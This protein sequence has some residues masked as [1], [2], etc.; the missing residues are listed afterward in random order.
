M[1]R[2]FF[3]LL[4]NLKKSY[5]GDSC[6][7]LNA[8]HVQVLKDLISFVETCNWSKS[9]ITKLY[10]KYWER[11]YEEL[12]VIFV[13]EGFKERACTTMRSQV[14]EIS[15][16]LYEMFGSYEIV[17]SAFSA[18]S[19]KSSRMTIK[20]GEMFITKLGMKIRIIN[21]DSGSKS[22]MSGL[23]VNLF[24]FGVECV[25]ENKYSLSECMNELVLLKTVSMGSIQKIC[26]E[27]DKDKLA[28]ILQALEKPFLIS[29]RKDV[30]KSRSYKDRPVGESDNYKVNKLY[31]NDLK[32][33]ILVALG[34]VK[35]K[36]LSAENASF[37][38]D[39]MVEES[40]GVDDCVLP[41]RFD[42][43]F[44]LCK[45]VQDL[46]TG[47]TKITD[48]EKY[49]KN[50]ARLEGVFKL[51]TTNGLKAYMEHFNVTDAELN[52]VLKKYE[53]I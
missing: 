48:M 22:F 51:F 30:V 9:D 15:R 29:E 42:S 5:L 13:K 37:E 12:G 50:V 41:Y 2:N 52:A 36:P 40:K 27:V 19:G 34:V 23:G 3:S 44:S 4:A 7:A 25:T 16:N 24:D 49:K 6:G 1:G 45:A 31:F 18:A 39:E 20:E 53:N 35:P 32:L 38:T 11:S 46:Y 47:D 14:S 17:E 33:D 26:D 28:F 21:A 43:M 10:C 8:E